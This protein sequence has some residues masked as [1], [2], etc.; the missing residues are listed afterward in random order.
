MKTTAMLF[1]AA[2][3]TA[4]HSTAP[5]QAE[6]GQAPDPAVSPA[7]LS[8]SEITRD[9]RNYISGLVCPNDGVVESAIA[10]SVK[11]RWAVPA[12]GLEEM[13]TTLEKLAAGGRTA[14]IRYKAYLAGLVFD[15]PAIF[16]GES[17]RDYPWD[18]DLFAAISGRAEKALLGYN[19]GRPA[20]K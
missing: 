13:R 16:K 17:G 15:S 9:E 7:L 6:A 1:A 8:V 5:C 19:A 14:A 3:V 10:L 18:E 2:L 4:A 11:M 12:A 20:G